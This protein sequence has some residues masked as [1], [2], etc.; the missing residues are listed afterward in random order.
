MPYN[1]TR[2]MCKCKALAASVPCMAKRTVRAHRSASHFWDQG[3]Q[4]GRHRHRRRPAVPAASMR[5]VGDRPA[6]CLTGCCEE[7][8]EGDGTGGATRAGVKS[9]SPASDFVR[10]ST[11]YPR[12]IRNRRP[13]PPAGPPFIGLLI[14]LR[15]P[16]SPGAAIP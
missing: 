5:V 9:P 16:L 8:E 13:V 12:H 4:R 15:P 10:F 7:E 14:I 11:G 1:K 2:D 3:E 6:G